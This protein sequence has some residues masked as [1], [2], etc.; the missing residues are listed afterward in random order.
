MYSSTGQAPGV[1]RRKDEFGGA[2]YVKKP[3]D[4]MV[5][6]ELVERALWMPH[7]V[8][9]HIRRPHFDLSPPAPTVL[10]NSSQESTAVSVN[11]MVFRSRRRSN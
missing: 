3:F 11:P 8:Q 10:A 4:P 9:T 1:I 5:L 2:Y 6:I 7:L